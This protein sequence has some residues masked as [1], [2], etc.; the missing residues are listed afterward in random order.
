MAR[1]DEDLH[2]NLFF[3]TLIR[4]NK[5]LFTEAGEK[6]WLVSIQIKHIKTI[7]CLSGVRP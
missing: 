3:M 5:L 7:S 6:R 1:Y 4:K 2:E